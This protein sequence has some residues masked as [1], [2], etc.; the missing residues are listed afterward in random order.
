[1][2]LSLDLGLGSIVTMGGGGIPAGYTRTTY[3]GVP[4]TLN[5]AAVFDD[6][7][8]FYYMRAA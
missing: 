5:G 7:L 3:N 6:G 4:V 8:N 1:M 2:R